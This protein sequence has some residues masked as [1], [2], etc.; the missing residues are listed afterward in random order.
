[1]KLTLH[2]QLMAAT[3]AGIIA[4]FSQIIIPVG[5][6]PWSLQTFIIGLS[7][8]LLGRRVGTWS[9]LIYFLLGLIG[10]PVF[11][12]GASGVAALFGPTGGYLI[13]FIF[14]SLIIGTIM[15]Y[16]KYNFFGQLSPT[17]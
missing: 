1:M 7:V 13:G 6:V 15:K 10:L 8:T 11:A 14:T 4:I 3:F 9:V 5:V 17:L 12:G 2:Q 16:R